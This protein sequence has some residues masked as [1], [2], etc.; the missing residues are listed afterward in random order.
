MIF[1]HIIKI[2]EKHLVTLKKLFNALRSANLSVRSSKC[3]LGFGNLEFFGYNVGMEMLFPCADKV[4]KISD[5]PCPKT[6]KEL[7]S[8]LGLGGYYRKFIPHFSD[9]CQPLTDLTRKGRPNTLVLHDLHLEAFSQLRRVLINPPILKLPNEQKDFI[10]Q[11]DASN[12][13]IGAV[14]LQEYDGVK[15][16]L[17]YISRRLQSREENFSTIERECLAII[18]A[19]QKFHIY[20]YGRPFLLQVD[21]QPLAYLN[22]NKVSNARL[23]RWAM[24]LQP[25]R[26]SI[27][28]IKGKDNIYG[29]YMSRI[30]SSSLE[31]LTCNLYIQ[32]LKITLL[33]FKD[34]NKVST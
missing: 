19:V 34:E 17:S 26:F 2:G 14:L 32:T 11:I 7:R 24:Q 13:A 16:P 10:L 20:L 8:F 28:S 31:G 30:D 29:D 22:K 3:M 27:E 12:H 18:W 6:K 9:L 23:M 4:R 33:D 5:A 1:L 15:F 25:Y 21:H